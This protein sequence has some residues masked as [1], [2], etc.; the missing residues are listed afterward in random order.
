MFNTTSLNIEFIEAM[1]D[2]SWVLM[3]YVRDKRHVLDHD[4]PIKP[5][6]GVPPEVLQSIVNLNVMMQQILV[7]YNKPQEEFDGE[8]P[9]TIIDTIEISKEGDSPSSS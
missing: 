9:E 7:T 5:R 8:I 2:I 1:Y 4:N 6:K 3:D